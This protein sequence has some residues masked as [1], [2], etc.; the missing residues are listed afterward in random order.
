MKNRIKTILL[1]L[2][3]PKSILLGVALFYFILI[4]MHARR[5]ADDNGLYTG[6]VWYDT[7]IVNNETTLLLLASAALWFSR[8]WSYPVAIGLSLLILVQ[9]IP[10]YLDQDRGLLRHREFAW[11]HG[12]NPFLQQDVQYLLSGIVLVYACICFGNSLQRGNSS[13]G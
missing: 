4:W 10:F 1:A 5:I 7:W 9:G 8:K 13:S 3:E 2:L 6:Y 12:L 11:A